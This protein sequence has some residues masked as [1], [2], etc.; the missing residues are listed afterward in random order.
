MVLDGVLN[1]DTNKDAIKIGI[2]IVDYLEKKGE[3]RGGLIQYFDKSLTTSEESA[4][5]VIMIGI[6]CG[7]QDFAAEFLLTQAY[8]HLKPGGKLVVSSSNDN[9]ESTDPLVSFLIQHLGAKDDPFK[10]W[11]LN[12]RK[13]EVMEKLLQVAGFKDIEIFS[14]TDYPGKEHLSHDILFGVD[15]LPA[16]VF[17]YDHPGVPLRLPPKEVLDKGTPYNWIAVATKIPE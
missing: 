14:D 9:M 12:F 3:L 16:E 2:G 6:I 10:G 11:G 13:K 4:D 15:T 1:Y 5:M 8:N 17:G 7:L